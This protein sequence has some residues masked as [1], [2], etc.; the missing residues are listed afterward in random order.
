MLLYS[1]NQSDRE[2]L[3]ICMALVLTRRLHCPYWPVRAVVNANAICQNELPDAKSG[4]R[5]TSYFGRQKK[6]NIQLNAYLS[7]IQL[8][9]LECE[10][11]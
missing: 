6:S 8:N 5:E 1:L 7:R 2:R 3:T 4:C 11:G 9:T 10:S